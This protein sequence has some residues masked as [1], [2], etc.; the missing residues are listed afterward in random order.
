MTGYYANITLYGPSQ[1]DVVKFLNGHGDIAYVAPFKSGAV[2]FHQDLGAQERL[3]IALSRHFRCPALVV[4]TFG[5]SI[6]LYELYQGGE[7]TDAYVSTPHEGLE[8][9]GPAQEGNP[10]VLCAAFG[11]DMDHKVR[12][13]ERVLRTPTR[14]NAEFALASN[15]HGELAR[16]LGLPLFAVGAGF[17]GIEIGELPQAADFDPSSLRRTGAA[18]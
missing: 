17:A 3:A 1:D 5:E 16:A 6:L 8:L 4:M 14:P 13:V 18:R 15:R 7:E 9:D 10:P 2:V 11:I 12:R